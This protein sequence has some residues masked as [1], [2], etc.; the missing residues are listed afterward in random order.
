ME[1]LLSKCQ[2]K[3][4]FRALRD[5][6]E[7]TPTANILEPLEATTQR[8]DDDQWAFRGQPPQS[9]D[10]AEPSLQSAAAE[11]GST[12]AQGYLQSAQGAWTQ[13]VAGYVASRWTT[14]GILHPGPEAKIQR[15]ERKRAAS[16]WHDATAAGLLLH[17]QPEEV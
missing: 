16:R 10:D 7:I 4:G 9:P 12:R 13:A 2:H 1:R 8:D 17:A 5:R 14:T 3:L 6:G 15:Q 11:D